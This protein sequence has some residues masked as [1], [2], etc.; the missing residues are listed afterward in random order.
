MAKTVEQNRKR[1]MQDA[2]SAETELE[3][4]VLGL[5]VKRA[6]VQT[7][8]NE[9]ALAQV[10]ALYERE[11]ET[12]KELLIGAE[13]K[14][15]DGLQASIKARRSLIA[16]LKGAYESDLDEARRQLAEFRQKNALLLTARGGEHEKSDEDAQSA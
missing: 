13:K 3:M 12:F 7:L 10:F 2:R 9:P 15:I 8:F 5:E 11:T 16:T 6:K 14:E 1:E 4:E